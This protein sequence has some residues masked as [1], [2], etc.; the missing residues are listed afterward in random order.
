MFVGWK[1]GGRSVVSRAEV[2]GMGGLFL[3]TATPLELGA[4]IEVVLDLKGGEVRARAIVRDSSAGKGMGVQFVQMDPIA[5]ARLNQFLSQ[6][7]SSEPERPELTDSTN[8]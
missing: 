3:H 7:D 4:N 2:V 6:F 5:R 1:A 8:P